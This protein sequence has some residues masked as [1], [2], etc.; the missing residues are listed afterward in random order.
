MLIQALEA[1][2][3]GFARAYNSQPAITPGTLYAQL[4]PQQRIDLDSWMDSVI[5]AQQEVVSKTRQI[6]LQPSEELKSFLSSSLKDSE[7]ILIRFRGL[8]AA[9][10]TADQKNIA[11]ATVKLQ[12]YQ[13]FYYTQRGPLLEKFNISA[14]EVGTAN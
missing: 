1:S 2:N 8:K 13:S 11:G 7:D 4:S 10:L 14:D 9:F 3:S 5:A 6:P 12:N